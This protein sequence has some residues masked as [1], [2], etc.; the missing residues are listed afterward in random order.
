MIRL[1]ITL[2]LL[3]SLSMAVC[4]QKAYTPKQGSLERKAI[5][6][7]MRK[8]CEKMLGQKVVFVVSHLKVQSGWAFSTGVPRQPNG[9]K[10]D[11]LKTQ[12]RE[13]VELGVFDDSYCTLL[14]KVGKTWKVKRFLIGMTDVPWVVW[15][16][17]FGAPKGIFPG[18][19]G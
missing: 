7:T 1:C 14:T 8:Q 3:A 4:A 13:Y 19:G 6:E 2:V 15:P 12:F 16:K 9:K 10:I 18:A 17:E 5:M 11:Y